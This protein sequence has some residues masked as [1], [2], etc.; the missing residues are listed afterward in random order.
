MGRGAALSFDN[1]LRAVRESRGWT[2]G[3]LARACGLSRQALSAIEAGRY[4]PNTAV[5][6]R[7]ARTLGCGVEDLF[8]PV[9]EQRVEAEW[10]GL[11]PSSRRVCVGRVR[12]RWVAWPLVGVWAARLADGVLAGETTRGR[13]PIH[14]H[15]S[16]ES[17]DKTLLVAGCDPALGIAASLLERSAGLAVR[18][19]PASSAEA[20]RA[21]GRGWVHV[22]GTHLHSPDDPDGSHTIRGALPRA[23]VQV[24]TLARWSEGLILLPGNPR[25]IRAPAD[26]LRRGVRIVN[27]DPGAGSRAVFERWVREAG[28][29]PDRI[30]G[31]DREL[32]SHFAVAEAVASGLADCG[33]GVLP[34]AQAYGLGFLTL[35]EQRYDL[36]IPKDLFGLPT[37]QRFLEVLTSRTFRRELEAVGGYDP[38]PAGA[39]RRLA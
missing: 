20:L 35:A 16:P 22:A 11:Q 25:R 38:A 5:A 8:V 24:I 15:S 34:V 2:Q 13:V 6:L 32:P 23:S 4:V 14:L 12:D 1:R 7:L 26:L 39:I 21:L 37:V 17:L 30:S 18:W 29:E 3:E 28:I 31:Y 27:R 9:S 36:V 33:P 10:A 19:I